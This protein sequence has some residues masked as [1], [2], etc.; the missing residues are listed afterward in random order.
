MVLCNSEDKDREA[1]E[2]DEGGSNA[3]W[4][5]GEDCP[6]GCRVCRMLAD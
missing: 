5:D 4:T 1:A 6:E 2:E 3:S